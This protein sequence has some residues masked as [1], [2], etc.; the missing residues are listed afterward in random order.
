MS[1]E[2]RM[3]REENQLNGGES[4]QRE[5]RQQEQEGGHAVDK[6]MPFGV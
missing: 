3:R 1:A 5:D 6:G 2:N 4:E